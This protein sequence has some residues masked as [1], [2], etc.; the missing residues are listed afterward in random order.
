MSA[1][2]KND[3][4]EIRVFNGNFEMALRIFRRRVDT[5][6]TFRLLKT[7]KQNP[8]GKMRNRHKKYRSLKRALR[9]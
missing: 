1:R 5:A 9:L 6:G 4:P 7:R 8:T 2:I 3:M